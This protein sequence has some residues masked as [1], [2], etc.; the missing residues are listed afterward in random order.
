MRASN[1]R[2]RAR[3]RVAAVLVLQMRCQRTRDQFSRAQQQLCQDR[4]RE[5]RQAQDQRQLL[6]RWATFRRAALDL[7]CLLERR[8]AVA[9]AAKWRVPQ[10]QPHSLIRQR[11]GGRRST[12][13][14][15]TIGRATATARAAKLETMRIIVGSARV[16]EVEVARAAAE[17][18]AVAPEVIFIRFQTTICHSSSSCV[19]DRGPRAIFCTRLGKAVCVGILRISQ[20]WMMIPATAIF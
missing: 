12:A 3:Q 8:R 14:D 6:D 19:F 2:H 5:Q 16:E 18:A 7:P 13:M 4:D 15:S 11:C 20:L 10:Q 1:A 17:W 9:L